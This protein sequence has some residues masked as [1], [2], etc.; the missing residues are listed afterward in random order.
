MDNTPDS[1]AKAPDLSHKATCHSSDTGA[2]CS[3]SSNGVMRSW[4]C[5]TM[6]PEHLNPDRHL[7]RQTAIR[8]WPLH[9]SLSTGFPDFHARWNQVALAVLPFAL[10]Q[11]SLSG[12]QF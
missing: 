8:G 1:P 11:E 5:S 7:Q 6:H 9:A 4:S 2:A 12:L 3:F 10:A